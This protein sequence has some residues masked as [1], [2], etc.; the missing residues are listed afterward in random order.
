MTKRPTLTAARV[1]TARLKSPHKATLHRVRFGME[2][3]FSVDNANEAKSGS[4]D[5]KE[6]LWKRYII[7]L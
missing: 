5:T 7:V 4:S 6:H 2:S 1:K 3:S